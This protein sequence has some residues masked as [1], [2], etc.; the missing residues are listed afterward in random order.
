MY[1]LLE[2]GHSIE[3]C[4]HHFKCIVDCCGEKHN[5]WLH[6]TE[7]VLGTNNHAD[8]NDSTGTVSTILPLQEL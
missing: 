1:F 4:R 8:E 5:K 2:V 6:E 7:Q 3:E